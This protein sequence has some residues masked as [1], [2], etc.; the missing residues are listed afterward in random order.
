MEQPKKIYTPS[1]APSSLLLYQGNAYLAWQGSLFAGALKLTHINRVEIDSNG[2]LI[3][4]ERLLSKM[5][6]RIRALL[7]G[8]DGYI[9]FSTDSGKILRLVPQE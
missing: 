3:G 7:E 6:E 1:I 8:P 2:A 4:E 5:G 9:Y